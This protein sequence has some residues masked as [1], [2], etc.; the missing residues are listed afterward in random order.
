MAQQDHSAI[1]AVMD[2]YGFAVDTQRWHLFDQVF[3]PDVDANWG[4]NAIWNDLEVFKRDFADYHDQF[5]GTHHVM[6]N[7]I[8][9]VEGDRA[10]T[11]TYGQWLLEKKG[12]PGGDVWRGEGW[13]NDELV[14]TE[15]GWRIAR[16]RCGII[17]WEGNVGVMGASD[18]D[19]Q[20]D[21]SPMRRAAD[22][23]EI[24]VLPLI[25][26]QG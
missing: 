24:G 8:A 23:G 16:R 10:K 21:T 25:E 22:R 6:L 5:D 26:A 11:V 1:K 2:L 18:V 12:C 15:K 7:L 9:D 14:R 3:L 17:R 20:L 19:F 13:Y 4:G